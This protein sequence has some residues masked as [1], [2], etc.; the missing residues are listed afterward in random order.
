MDATAGVKSRCPL[1]GECLTPKIIYRANVSNYK[2]SGKRFYF[3]FTGDFKHEKYENCNELAIYIWQ[4]KCCNTN[5]SISGNPSSI[6]C[7]SS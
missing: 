2:N 4:L 3:G 5:F 7:P 1:N 6:I